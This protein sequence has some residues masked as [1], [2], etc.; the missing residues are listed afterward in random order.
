MAIPKQLLA[1]L[2]L[3]LATQVRAAPPTQATTA[4]LVEEVDEKQLDVALSDALASAD[5]AVRTIAA[6]VAT[7]RGCTTLLPR[8]EPLLNSERDP[9]AARELVRAAILLGGAKNID[10]AIA[11][12]ARF[13]HRLDAAV[14][15]AMARLGGD[16]ALDAYR[17]KLVK[18]KVA[19][20]SNFFLI[21]L[22]SAPQA[23][24]VTAEKLLAS[25][26]EKG[27]RAF[28]G[29]VT[30]SKLMLDP[31]NLAAALGNASESI[32]ADTINAIVGEYSKNFSLTEAVK[33]TLRGSAAPAEEPAP[34]AF[35]REL[36]RRIGGAEPRS[37]A[38]W[39]AWIATDPASSYFRYRPALLGLFTAEERAVVT[40]PREKLRVPKPSI[41]MIEVLP[42]QFYTPDVLPNGVADAILSA[43]GCRAEWVGLG[44]M[45]VDRAGRVVSLDISRVD[46]DANCR[47]AIDAVTRLTL[48][49]PT[50]IMSAFETK[51]ALFVKPARSSLCIDEGLVPALEDLN[52]EACNPFQ[53]GGDSPCT[54]PVTRKRVE[55]QWPSGKMIPGGGSTV[56]ILESIVTETGC[57]RSARFVTQSPFAELN[58]SAILALLGW[59]FRPATIGGV[60]VPVVFNLTIN[61]KGN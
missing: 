24:P 16:A 51:Y 38:Q 29:A 34:V 55:P 35:K 17:T 32:R 19:P 30:D 26:D 42:P 33:T 12:S 45:K 25:H 44:D 1:L 48:V 59:K 53:V 23:I 28:I 18:L 2:L 36:L 46:T 21:A 3:A 10:A 5:P 11:A 27:W 43:T 49:H 15:V 58:R 54:P 47:K 6:R 41:P 22:W 57:V 31:V 8:I 37:S 14:A 60:P 9:E 61:F 52:L 40:A 7:V 50:S 4:M 13:G 20:Q 56:V 39:L